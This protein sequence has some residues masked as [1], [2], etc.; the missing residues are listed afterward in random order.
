[1]KKKNMN[2]M[3]KKKKAL[4]GVMEY[5]DYHFKLTKEE[6]EWVKQFYDEYHGGNVTKYKEPILT[7]SEHISEAYRNYNALYK[8]AF[9]VTRMLHKQQE[10]PEDQR[11]IYE[12]AADENDYE[13][14]FIRAET[15]EQGYQD[16][17]QVVMDQAI[18]DLDAGQDKKVVLSRFHVK[19]VRLRKMMNDEKRKQK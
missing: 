11:E 6:K 16:G 15:P 10:I 12:L 5:K 13:T 8:D 4:E 3:A 7:A 2:T 1:M 9:N 17:T 19:M 18:R 14:A